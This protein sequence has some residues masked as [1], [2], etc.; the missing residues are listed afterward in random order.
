MKTHQIAVNTSIYKSIAPLM[1][2][3][4]WIKFFKHSLGN[5][6]KIQ[7]YQTVKSQVTSIPMLSR[8]LRQ[9]IAAPPLHRHVERLFN[10]FKSYQVR[11]L[12]MHIFYKRGQMIIIHVEPI[13]FAPPELAPRKLSV[14]AQHLNLFLGNCWLA[15]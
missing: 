11:N 4:I 8:V 12:I 13:C 3:N 9:K 6:L 2:S 1:L 10:F 15:K 14:V 5:P 7:K